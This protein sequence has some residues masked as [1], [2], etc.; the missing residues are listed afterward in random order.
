MSVPCSPHTTATFNAV[1]QSL[2]VPLPHRRDVRLPHPGVA[3]PPQHPDAG[4]ITLR[5]RDRARHIRHDLALVLVAVLIACV[6]CSSSP[7]AAPTITGAT[8]LYSYG[9]REVFMLRAR[10]CD[11]VC[12]A[13]GAYASVAIVHAGDCRNPEHRNGPLSRTDAG[14]AHE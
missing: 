10:S 2:P 8:P 7:A 14:V 11:Y 4:A 1:P 12:V 5:R 9:A 6:S 3:L 13:G